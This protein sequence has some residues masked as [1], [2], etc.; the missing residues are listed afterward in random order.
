MITRLSVIA[1]RADL[2]PGR[3]H[4]VSRCRPRARARRPGV[5]ARGERLREDDPAARDRR[6]AEA[7]RRERS[8]GRGATRPLYY[9]AHANALKGDLTIVES[10]APSPCAFTG[11]R[12]ETTPR[13]DAT[14]RR[15]GLYRRRAVTHRRAR[16]RKASAVVSRWRRSRSAQPHATVD[17]RRAVRR[18][19]QR[20]ERRIVDTLLHRACRRRVAACCSR[21]TSRRRSIRRAM[22]IVQLDA[23]A[24]A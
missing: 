11:C 18:A 24:A 17:P 6:I 4:A 7:R 13:L 23:V 10:L 9:L 2:Q 21:A 14:L 22:R 5:A 16:C 12:R 1:P 3:P 8:P 20:R 15:F 19:G